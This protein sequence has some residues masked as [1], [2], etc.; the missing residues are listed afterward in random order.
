ELHALRAGATG[1]RQ[2]GGAGA[3]SRGGRRGGGAGVES[4]GLLRPPPEGNP[5]VGEASED[6]RGGATRATRSAF[7]RP[8]GGARP[9]ACVPAIPAAILSCSARRRNRGRGG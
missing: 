3:G 7:G 6:A 4:G 9:P 1:G 8:S 2:P 5:A